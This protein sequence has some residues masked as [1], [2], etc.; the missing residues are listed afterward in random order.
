MIEYAQGDLLRTDAEAL[1]NTVNCVG[2]MGRGIALQFRHTF[3]DNFKAYETACKREQVQPGRMFVYETG[4]I[5]NPK[6]II[7]FPTKRGKSR[8]EDID[9]GLIALRSEVTKRKIRSIAIPP[10]GSGLGGLQWSE[11]KPRIEK[12]MMDLDNVKVIVFEPNDSREGRPSA[13]SRTVP[14]M[15]SGR[16]A[17]IRLME[18]YLAGL[19]DP[20][21]SL[22][23]VHKLMY[24]M[25]EAG[26]PLKLRYAKAAYGPYAENLRHVLSRIEGHMIAGYEDGGDAPLKHL[27]LVP[28]ATKDAESFLH[29][30]AETR[31]RLDRVARLVEGFETPFG[32][33]LLSTVHW[34]LSREGVDTTGDVV[35][36]VY[37][38][39]EHK[40]RFSPRQIKVAVD[41]LASQGWA[42]AQPTAR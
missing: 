32:L 8:I 31:E 13:Q 23:E 22:L 1:V 15:T 21:V 9:M 3:P 17:L 19:L 41:T 40:K 25:Q 39:G 16:A 26:Q 28:G 27:E 33:E 14:H 11:V 20:F 2:I 35:S 24:F 7:N 5:T 6:Y 4:W 10:L 38:W 37:A 30:D 18:R 42:K 12:A 29:N 36:V 34:L